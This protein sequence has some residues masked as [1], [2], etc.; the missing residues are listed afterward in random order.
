[1]GKL[2]SV[3]RTPRDLSVLGGQALAALGPTALD[4]LGAILGG[5]PRAEAVTA[6]AHESRRLEGPLHVVHS[7]LENERRD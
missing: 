2:A 7:G 1:M 6:L 3:T 4:N 5:H